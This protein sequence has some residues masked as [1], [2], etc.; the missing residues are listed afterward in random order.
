MAGFKSDFLSNKF[1][2]HWLCGLPYTAPTSV[3]IRLYTVAPTS[4]GLGTPVSGGSYADV[5][6]VCNTTNFSTPTGKVVKNLTLID[7]GSATA[8]WGAI[9]GA[10]FH[11][12]ADDQFLAYGPFGTP[13]TVL[14]GGSFSI[15]PNAGTFTEA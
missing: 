7:F 12:A 4:A 2:G 8:D 1:L 3:K 10:A 5:T 9:V 6:K 15:A 13:V 14:N 11:D